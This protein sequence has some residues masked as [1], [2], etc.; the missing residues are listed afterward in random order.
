MRETP[1][2]HV[3]LTEALTWIAFGE[4]IPSDDLRKQIEG[5]WPVDT[6]C[7]E[8][9][10]QRFFSRIEEPRPLVPGFGYFQDRE[11]GLKKLSLAWRGL[12][13]GVGSGAIQMWGRY[14]SNFTLADARLAD[15]VTLTPEILMVFRQFDVT[16]G[17]IRRWPE[18]SPDVLWE[19]HPSSFGREF[20]SFSGD[21]RARDGYLL[22]QIATPGLF[23]SYPSDDA[24]PANRQLNHTQIISRAEAMRAERPGISKGSVAASI[25]AELGSN[26]RTKKPR[27]QRG[28]ER[29]IG[30]LW[31]GGIPESP[32]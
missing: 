6:E 31:E 2:D 8:E 32:L 25:V 26:P 14:T 3:S 15:A 17:G 20:A 28:I 22:I 24:I 29:I 5:D 4:L 11:R 12:R 30:H 9:R 18:G 27:D 19:N 13:R 23:K 1:S 21:E 7:T 10:L 16:T